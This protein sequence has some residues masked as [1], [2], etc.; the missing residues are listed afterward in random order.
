[1]N[2]GIDPDSN[3][4]K[5]QEYFL[6]VE[7]GQYLWPTILPPSKFYFLEIWEPQ[8]PEKLRDCTSL[9]REIAHFST[10]SVTR[11]CDA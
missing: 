11:R 8:P 5:Y 9:F 2:H 3:R 10:S 1:M 6:L 7:G 4:N